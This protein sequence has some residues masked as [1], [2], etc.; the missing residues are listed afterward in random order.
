M[1]ARRAA[2]LQ[3]GHALADGLPLGEVLRGMSPAWCQ[4]AAVDF[5]AGRLRAG[6]GR[7]GLPEDLISLAER[8]P[9]A[10]GPAQR[11]LGQLPTAGGFRVPMVASLGY[12]LVLSLFQVVVALLITHRVEPAFAEMG[13]DAP[14]ALAPW[15]W[16]ASPGVIALV[17]LCLLA[18]SLT[19]VLLPGR[20]GGWGVHLQRAREACLAAA[21]VEAGAP[22][23]VQRQL[24]AGFRAFDAAPLGLLELEATVAVAVAEAVR[25]H[26]RA[27]A[28]VRLVG[29]GVLALVA[30]VMTAAI[31]LS[32]SQVGIFP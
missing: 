1:R 19:S 29:T 26:Q 27:V 16:V 14:L 8:C 21:V 7:I 11:R 2:Q 13:L 28:G 12:L 18:L 20:L 6:L 23:G 30:A 5:E 22:V 3:A 4:A 15:V 32:L 31:Y 25:R 24:A 10:L 17:V 9:A